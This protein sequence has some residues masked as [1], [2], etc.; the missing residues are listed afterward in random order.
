MERSISSRFPEGGSLSARLQP[1]KV[2]ARNNLFSRRSRSRELEGADQAR[3]T[4]GGTKVN[5][6]VGSDGDLHVADRDRDPRGE[7]VLDDAV[8]LRPGNEPT[9]GS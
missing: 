3:L 6:T 4:P 1:L 5:D 2:P 8:G 9:I 7:L